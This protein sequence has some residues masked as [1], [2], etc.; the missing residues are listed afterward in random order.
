MKASLYI[1]PV[2]SSAIV[3]MLPTTLLAKSQADQRGAE[4]SRES[5][6]QLEDEIGEDR[7]EQLEIYNE[8][9]YDEYGDGRSYYVDPIVLKSVDLRPYFDEKDIEKVKRFNQIF[10]TNHQLKMT[11]KGL[12]SISRSKDADWITHEIMQYYTYTMKRPMNNTVIIDGTAGIGGNTISFAKQFHKVISVELNKVHY[13]VLEN[14]V[15][16]LKMKNVDMIHGSIMESYKRFHINREDAI[17]FMDPPW[18]GKRYKN[19]KHFVMKMGNTLIYHFI[20]DLY[21]AGYPMV[22]LKAPLNLNINMIVGNVSYT[23][24]RI[25]KEKFMM[26]LI[27]S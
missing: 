20:E 23:S 22:V 10:K 3:P 4:S 13:D 2:E 17:F 7:S 21:K 16:V 11:D 24:F 27:F 12:Y 25:V 18:G 26:L 15:N 19:F 5:S 14:N 6:E 1:P 8:D 9:E